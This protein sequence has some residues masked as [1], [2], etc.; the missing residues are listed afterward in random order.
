MLIQLLE[1]RKKDS[2]KS[3]TNSSPGWTHVS[4]IILIGIVLSYE[5]VLK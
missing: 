1:K 2:K 5:E 3:E 4:E